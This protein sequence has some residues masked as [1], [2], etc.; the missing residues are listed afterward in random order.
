MSG[1]SLD[2]F[3]P[4]EPDP[5]KA[6]QSVPGPSATVAQG[7]NT[8][9]K[10]KRDGADPPPKRTQKQARYAYVAHKFTVSVSLSTVMLF[11]RRSKR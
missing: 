7:T 3:V 11:K 4:N 5:D 6:Y 2:Y 10:R 8:G 1:Q 9:S